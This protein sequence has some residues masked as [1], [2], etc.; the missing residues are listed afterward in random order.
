MFEGTAET[1]HASLAKLSD[2]S[3]F[4]DNTLL[5]PGH[6]YSLVNLLFSYKIDGANP[7]VAAKLKRSI[8]ARA[9]STGLV[10]TTLGEERGYNR[11][12][13]PSPHRR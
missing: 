5:F 8:D 6:E 13:P 3:A 1:M 12:P 10:P 2:K 7:K 11:A 4:P 9:A